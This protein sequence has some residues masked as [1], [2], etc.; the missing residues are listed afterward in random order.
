MLR[1]YEKKLDIYYQEYTNLHY[2]NLKRIPTTKFKELDEQHLRFDQ[3]HTKA[4]LR[5]EKLTASLA[6]KLTVGEGERLVLE[7]FQNKQRS[8]GVQ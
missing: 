2:E 7:G 1:A 4:L 5:I 3:L 6:S 8:I